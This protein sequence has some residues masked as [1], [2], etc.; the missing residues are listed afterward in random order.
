MKNLLSRMIGLTPK[1]D[2]PRLVADHF[3]EL[4][5]FGEHSGGVAV[6]NRQKIL[7]QLQLGCQR[8]M[9]LLQHAL[10]LNSAVILW[11]GPNTGQLSVYASSSRFEPLQC[12]PF[13]RGIGVT[14]ALKEHSELILVPVTESSPA[15]PY[16]QNHRQVGSFMAI[17]LMI[18]GDRSD[19]CRRQEG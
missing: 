2:F 14:G 12:G 13:P 1:T 10:R 6:P 15:I 5:F 16:Y 9:R 8:Q 3:T 11:S 4:P 17:K 18:S 7:R 19:D